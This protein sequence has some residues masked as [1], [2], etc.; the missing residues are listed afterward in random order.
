MDKRPLIGK[1]LA[2]G[3]ILLFIGTCIIPCT[4]KDNDKP[5]LPTSRSNWL[6]VGGSGPGNYTKIQDAVDDASDG[7]T[8]FVYDDSAPYHE[9]IN[10]NKSI[11]LLGENQQT[12]IIDGTGF[13]DSMITINALYVTLFNLT[14]KNA[15][16]EGIMIHRSYATISQITIQDSSGYSWI[17]AI[18]VYP[19]EQQTWISID[20]ILIQNNTI[21]RTWT[22]IELSYCN[23]A[24]ITGNVLLDNVNGIEVIGSFHN[25]ISANFISG[26]EVGILDYMS[27]KNIYRGNTMLNNTCGMECVCSTRDIIEKNNFLNNTR[28]AFFVKALYLVL[29]VIRN[30]LY[31]HN[32][33]FLLNYRIIRPTIWNQNYWNESRI[34]PYVIVGE[35]VKDPYDP[36]S[37]TKRFNF[38]MNPAKEPYDISPS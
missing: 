14:L 11:T 35:A 2:V 18:T 17:G 1:W 25:E 32:F 22:G 8:V 20:K 13:P 28:H 19:P 3:I 24:M 33:Y 4:A 7:D 37:I 6:Y 26:S 5:T 38:D 34:L 30:M 21:I 12:T 29:A 9:I 27:G 10:I 15:E 23:Q 31:A 36:T 16:R